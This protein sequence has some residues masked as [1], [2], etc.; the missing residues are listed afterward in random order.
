MRLVVVAHGTR[1][2]AGVA[3]TRRLAAAVGAELAFVDVLPPRLRDVLAR[4]PGPVTVVPAFLA[5]GYH[6]RVDVP[7]E[8][9][10]AGRDDVTVT[11]AL[12]PAVAAAAAARLRAA[13]W[14]PGDAVL[15]AAVG[16]SDPRASLDVRRAAR[17][18]TAVLRHPVGVCSV[19]SLPSVVAGLQ[20][21]GRRVAVAPWLL[22][23]GVFHRAATDCGAAVV[24]DPL[25]T[26]PA[27]LARLAALA[28]TTEVARSA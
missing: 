1:D 18:L 19:P 13:G 12:G 6:V 5:A 2:P 8:V 28:G 10:A 27:V 11:A 17:G 3:V 21:T 22:A 23:P 24:G 15:L 25:G 26:H 16:S 9:A 7:A 20:A 4:V 14:R